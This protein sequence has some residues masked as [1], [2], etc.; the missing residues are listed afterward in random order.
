M[1]TKPKTFR[2]PWVQRAKQQTQQQYDQRRGSACKR[3]YDSEWQR[4]RLWFL[5]AHP[6]CE[7]PGCHEIATEVDHIV[8]LAQGGAH[9]SEANSQGLCKA[10]HTSKTNRENGRVK[11]HNRMVK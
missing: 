11:Q 8:P 6:L 2:P 3:G 4:F 1:P 9:C 5:K 7:E 10:H